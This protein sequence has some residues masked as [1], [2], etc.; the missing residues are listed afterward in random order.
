[1]SKSE[2]SLEKL[3]EIVSIPLYENVR[4]ERAYVHVVVICVC[5]RKRV[6]V[7]ARGGLTGKVRKGEK[8]RERSQV[9]VSRRGYF[10]EY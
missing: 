4:W 9:K 1:M 3:Y 7:G 10:R 2:R 6:K 8:E 5:V